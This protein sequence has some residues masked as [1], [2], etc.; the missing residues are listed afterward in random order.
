MPQTIS[1]EFVHLFLYCQHLNTSICVFL[2]WFKVS[3]LVHFQEIYA[4][5]V[6]NTNFHQFGHTFSFWMSQTRS[7]NETAAKQNDIH[8]NKKPRVFSDEPPSA[9]D[10]FF[11]ALSQGLCADWLVCIAFC[12]FWH[13][14]GS[15]QLSYFS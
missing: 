6:S 2:F 8:N 1:A 12:I 14:I 4:L 10:T 11:G 3:L 15:D 13:L 7:Q 9:N 5:I